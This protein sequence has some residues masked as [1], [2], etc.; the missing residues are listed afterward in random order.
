[1]NM[2]HYVP[3]LVASLIAALPLANAADGTINVKG[4]IQDNTCEVAVDSQSVAVKL[5]NVAS[6][7]FREAG[8]TSLPQ[9]FIINLE[10]CG[11][12]V[13]NVS[14]TFN[15]TADASDSTLLAI[16]AGTGNAAGL[17][18]AIY[19]R[20]KALLPINT[21]GEST[22]LEANQPAVELLFYANFIANG[23]PVVAGTVNASAT[24]TLH[25][26]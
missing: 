18:I 1:M 19:D 20:D 26:A 7:D 9:A 5:G 8:D 24:F 2:K 13:S 15:G 10:Q 3:V 14:V 25:Y 23:Q 16:P 17:G 21:V 12:A 11:A 4:H 22:K 6:K